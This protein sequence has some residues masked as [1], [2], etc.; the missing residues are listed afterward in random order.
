MK[1]SVAVRGFGK[2]ARITQAAIVRITGIAVCSFLVEH[3]MLNAGNQYT[4]SIPASAFQAG[5]LVRWYIQVTS[6]T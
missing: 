1:A 4:A 6:F 5:D 2:Q 3:C